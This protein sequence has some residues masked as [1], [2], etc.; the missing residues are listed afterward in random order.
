[1]KIPDSPCKRC[2]KKTSCS[3]DGCMEWR[4]WFCACWKELRERFLG[5]EP[6]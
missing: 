5:K 6:E 4:E 2:P 3:G 1:M